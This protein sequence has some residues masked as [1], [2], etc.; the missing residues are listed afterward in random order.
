MVPG[1]RG[2]TAVD[3]RVRKRIEMNRAAVGVGLVAG[4]L[5]L[6][7]ILAAVRGRMVP[8]Q[9][10]AQPSTPPPQVGDCVIENPNDLGADLYTW[11][12]VLPSVSTGRC[13][14]AGWIPVRL[15]C[16]A[17]GVSCARRPDG[18]TSR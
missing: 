9:G 12:A 18:V 2:E 3:S 5:L 11:T 4:A 14:G 16:G 7:L 10:T 15:R 13:P 8:G 6:V 17:P 1:G